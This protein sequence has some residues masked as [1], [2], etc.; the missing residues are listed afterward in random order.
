MVVELVVVATLAQRCRVGL[1]VAHDTIRLQ[2]R[3]LG[4]VTMVHRAT[5]VA[6]PAWGAMV[7]VV[8]A[9]VLEQWEAMV[10]L[11]TKEAM[12]AMA[13]SRRSQALRHGMEEVVEE[14]ST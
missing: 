11:H 13:S 1:V 5:E 9:V 12:E 7:V 3:M 4:R 6:E 10:D 14:G 2:T 8:V